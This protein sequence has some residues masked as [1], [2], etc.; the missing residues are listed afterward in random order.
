[1]TR[2]TF[3]NIRMTLEYDGTNYAG[4]Q[5]QANAMTVQQAVEE[6]LENHL[7]ENIRV[8]ASG[9]T[10]AG[11]HARAQVINFQTATGIP[12]DAIARGLK[13]WLPRDIA[14]LDSS[15]VSAEFDARRSARLRW[16]RF[17]ISNRRPRHAIGANYITPVVGDLSLSLMREAADILAGDH[18]FR[19][20]RSVACTATR[21]QL[22][23]HPIV[24]TPLPGDILQLDFRCRSFLHNMVRILTG[25]LIS[26]G[27][28]KLLLTDIKSMLTTGNRHHQAITLAPS[29]LF[30]W[31]IS[32]EETGEM[33]AHWQATD[34]LQKLRIPGT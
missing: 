34:G 25:C 26:A 1:M 11:V 19:A 6:A 31:D 2:Q 20:F 7:G 16:Y 23:L 14:A 18:D 27:R 22:T 33:P 12:P 8:T 15:A 32:Y 28:H 24:L 3:T 4:W 29:G 17:Y 9:R 5:R 10:D 13:A 21:T 30:L